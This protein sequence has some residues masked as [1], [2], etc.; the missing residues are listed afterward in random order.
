MKK[1]KFSLNGEYLGFYEEKEYKKINN[2]TKNSIEY[3]FINNKYVLNKN[4]FVTLF[5]KY[6]P[7]I[8]LDANKIPNDAIFSYSIKGTNHEEL[9][10][11]NDLLIKTI[12]IKGYK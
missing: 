3:K 1:N 10:F 6:I 12:I 4:E 5:H 8:N 11:L 7:N 2:D 9:K